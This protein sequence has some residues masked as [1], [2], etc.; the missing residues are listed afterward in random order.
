[1]L[2]LDLDQ[3]DFFKGHSSPGEFPVPGIFPLPFSFPG[4]D[5]ALFFI[6]S[7]LTLPQ[8][9]KYNCKPAEN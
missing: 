6:K 9:K 1:M 7:E 4:T 3:D 2:V 5:A 8:W